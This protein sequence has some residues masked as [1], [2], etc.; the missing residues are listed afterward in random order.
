MVIIDGQQQSASFNQQHQ[1][2]Q[3]WTAAV[4]R[5]TTSVISC[6]NHNLIRPLG[7]FR[8]SEALNLAE[9]P[10][11][12][13]INIKRERDMPINYR[14]RERDNEPPPSKRSMSTPA[15]IDSVHQHL[16]QDKSAYHEMHHDRSSHH[17]DHD[18]QSD[19]SLHEH[20]TSCDEQSVRRLSTQTPHQNGGSVA[21]ASSPASILSGMQF[22]F[23]SRGKCRII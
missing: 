20:M 19:T 7:S 14:D 5:F 12:I 1:P 2:A 16:Q 21:K 6:G 15:N 9:S 8:Y 11:H 18:D 17:D 13:P 22:N 3:S 4:S 10:P 23:T